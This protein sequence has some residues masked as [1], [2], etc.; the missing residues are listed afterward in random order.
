MRTPI[1]ALLLLASLALAFAACTTE[2]GTTPDCESNIAENGCRQ[3][4]FCKGDPSAV[5]CCLPDGGL[6]DGG[7]TSCSFVLCRIGYG[8][9]ASDPSFTMAEL[10][11]ITPAGTTTT[12]SSGGG[13]GGTGAGG[14]GAGGGGGS[15]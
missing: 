1:A 9:P 15:G 14:G 6:P 10:E 4:P 13:E 12:T 8:V 5:T 11:C 3:F 2:E 7:P